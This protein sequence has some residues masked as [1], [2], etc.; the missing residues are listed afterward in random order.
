MND[1]T[2]IDSILCGVEHQQH[3][4][5]NSLLKDI[6][7]DSDI[8]EILG[9]EPTS[10][11]KYGKDILPELAA[12]FNHIT[13]NGLNKDT[14]KELCENYLI[15]RN[16]TLIGAPTLNPEIKAALNEN[17]L[18]RD[19]LIELRQKRMAG[20]ISCIGEALSFAIGEKER[21][22]VQIKRLMDTARL[23]CD[24]QHNDSVSR[25]NLA[26]FALKKE[27]KEPLLN[28]KIDQ[29]LFG[30][31]LTESLK[32]AKA[33]NKSGTELKT[34]FKPPSKNWKTPV[35]GRRQPA[36][37]HRSVPATPLAPTTPSQPSTVPARGPRKTSAPSSRKPQLPPQRSARRRY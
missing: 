17:I 16:C 12:R 30:E 10:L 24:A 18:K 26:V 4:E 31:S 29:S 19:K 28:T 1:V 33:V 8:L 35:V 3:E 7:L 32:A 22:N 21:N 11:V 6:G 25:R 13:T 27:M 2:E 5:D 20:A 34:S 14:R 36:I 23:I 15:P 37:N 9:E